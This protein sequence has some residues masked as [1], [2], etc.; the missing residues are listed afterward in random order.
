MSAATVH[1]AIANVESLVRAA[2]RRGERCVRLDTAQLPR[3]A[4]QRLLARFRKDGF[5][6]S[7][8]HS[9]QPR[10]VELRW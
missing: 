5:V 1:R 9:N 10:V 8:P 7:N 2:E 6:V 3:E 4:T